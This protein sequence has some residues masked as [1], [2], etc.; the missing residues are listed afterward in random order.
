MRFFLLVLALVSS[1]AISAPPCTVS[2]IPALTGHS[3]HV[4]RGMLIDA[5]FMP[6]HYNPACTGYAPQSDEATTYGYFEAPSVAANDGYTWTSPAGQLF[7]LT[8]FHPILKPGKTAAHHVR[9]PATHYRAEC[10]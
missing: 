8:P 9:D 4:A 3:Y 7:L 2:G 10:L 1:P 6:Q 5:G